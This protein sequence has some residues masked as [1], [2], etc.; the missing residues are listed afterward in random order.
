MGSQRGSS[1]VSAPSDS[2]L[3]TSNRSRWHDLPNEL[4][5][6]VLRSAIASSPQSA[7]TLCFVSSWTRALAIDHLRVV[8]LNTNDDVSRFNRIVASGDCSPEECCD[9]HQHACALR[10]TVKFIWMDGPK[11][12][13]ETP[14]RSL[15]NVIDIA[16]RFDLLEEILYG[17]LP[18]QADFTVLPN[19]PMRL[20]VHGV[21]V[22]AF[23][24]SE[25]PSRLA[26]VTVSHM[27]FVT[28]R[29]SDIRHTLSHIFPYPYS[30][31]WYLKTRH[32]AIPFSGNNGEHDA[33][34]SRNFLKPILL[35]QRIDPHINMLVLVFYRNEMAVQ[36]TS[37]WFAKVRAN[38]QRIYFA[39]ADFDTVEERWVEEA[40]SGEGIWERAVRETR[41]WERERDSGAALF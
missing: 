39:S 36:K 38:D 10:D 21:Y 25:K 7:L 22:P 26:Q 18:P 4:I 13:L 19:R 14:L 6:W 17:L 5:V 33:L 15:P 28:T 8:V 23:S 34:L 37:E 30:L 1:L 32:I 20:T 2:L 27:Y 35:L 11:N 16:I 29:T 3:S 41:A 24:S 9:P 12:T 31:A 40:R